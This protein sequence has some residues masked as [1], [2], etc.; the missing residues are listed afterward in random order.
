M[1]LKRFL[2]LGCIMVAMTLFVSCSGEDGADGVP[3]ATGP[4]GTTGANGTD[5]TDGTNGA[6]GADGADGQ[7]GI[8]CWDLNG[9]GVGN[10]A[11]G[12][13]GGSEDEDIN[14]DG[15]VDALD[16]QGPQG[17][18]GPG[19]QRIVVDV[20]GIA[21]DDTA[22]NLAVP[23]LTQEIVDNYVLLFYLTDGANY[24]PIPGSTNSEFQATNRQ[25][26][27]SYSVGN[28]DLLVSSFDGTDLTQG[29]VTGLFTELHVVL[30]ETSSMGGKSQAD[31]MASLKSAGVDT[32]DYHAVMKHYGME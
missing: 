20:T 13:D 15:V 27:V 9:D 6:D 17:D 21:V 12:G 24:F 22:I 19:A 30:V 14:D 16:C 29:W 11:V 10:I 5:G 31:V 7:D 32:N 26:N 25:Y 23:E 2:Q 4:A 1:K 8:A 18:S 28:V 3:G